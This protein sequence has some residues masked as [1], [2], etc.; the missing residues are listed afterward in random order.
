[1]EPPVHEVRSN[2]TRRNPSLTIRR[3]RRSRNPPPS[4]PVHTQTGKHEPREAEHWWSA[5]CGG[6][7]RAHDRQ[8]GAAPAR[9]PD[10]TVGLV[11]KSGSAARG[12][13]QALQAPRHLRAVP[14]RDQDCPGPRAPALWQVWHQRRCAA[15]R[16]LRLQLPPPAGAAR[17]RQHDQA[18]GHELRSRA[19]MSRWTIDG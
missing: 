18:T 4:L 15:P 10:R 3:S 8:A 19:H 14:L 5:P 12:D 13:R 17:V 6:G 7:H 16:R 2:R 9:A 1:M 11:H